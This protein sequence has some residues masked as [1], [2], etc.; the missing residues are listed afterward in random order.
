MRDLYNISDRLGAGGDVYGW[1]CATNR[2]VRINPPP[3]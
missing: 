3:E 2:L 1:P